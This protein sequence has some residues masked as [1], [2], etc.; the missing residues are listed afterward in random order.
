VQHALAG[1]SFTLGLVLT[2]VCRLAPAQSSGGV[3]VGAEAGEPSQTTRIVL[4]ASPGMEE[5]AARF[6]AELGSLRLDV[7][8]APDAEIAPSAAE[9][10]DLARGHRARAAVRVSRT[11]ATVELWLVNPETHEVLYRR[12]VTEGDPAVAVLRSLEILRGALVDLQALEAEPALQAKPEPARGAIANPREAY[13][14]AKAPHP[15]WLAVSGTLLAARAGRG[16]G[17]GAT[18]GVHGR[19]G[20]RFVLHAE[21]LGPL[22]EWSVEG[23]GGS[24]KIR[25]GAAT[26]GA[27]VLPWDG[28][29]VTPALGLGVGVLALQT[30]GEARTGYRGAS[31]LS[32]AAFPHGRL[33]LGIALTSSVRLKGAFVAGF[34]APRPVLLFAEQREEA[35]LNPLFLSSVGVEVPLR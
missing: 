35:W 18:A 34:A 24:A 22:S 9:L 4:V 16:L 11:G 19:V 17:G 28:E 3:E 13:E 32:L 8:R 27:L 15:L 31:D 7:V 1:A 12:V 6:V 25:A 23:Q 26:L 33:E 21:V 10:E 14:P 5:L 29:A 30:R 2:L 20:S